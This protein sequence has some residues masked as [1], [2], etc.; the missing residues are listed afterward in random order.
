[1]NF[2]KKA[3]PTFAFLFLCNY[4]RAD[5]I[6]C[7]TLDFSK[8]GTFTNLIVPAGQSVIIKSLSTY[9]YGT[10]ELLHISGNSTNNLGRR[11]MNGS[12]LIYFNGPCV[13]GFPY[14]YDTN[15]K[16]GV[17]YKSLTTQPYRS[18]I[19][20]LGSNPGPYT[21]NE[22]LFLDLAQNEKMTILGF[23]GA[24]GGAAVGQDSEISVNGARF[25]M[26]LPFE[27]SG[28]AQVRYIR[29]A[30]GIQFITYTLSSD[31][32]Q[33]ANSGYI[34]NVAGQVELVVEKSTDLISWSPLIAKQ[35]EATS[36]EKEFFRIRM[37]R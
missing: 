36:G 7:T 3:I 16:H 22:D 37:A 24:S 28:P 19:N 15:E 9:M 4:S 26:S 25:R 11:E 32:T 31:Y 12:G 5:F 35:V 14:I 17:L 21:N 13:I 20:P 8:E 33:F 34:E 10:K 23:W 29:P 2:F 1:V 18:A 6:D 27:I 30:S